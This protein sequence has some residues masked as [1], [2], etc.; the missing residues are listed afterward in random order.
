MIVP[1]SDPGDLWLRR[2]ENPS[3]DALSLGQLR[4]EGDRREAKKLL[5][6]ARRG[7]RAI[8]DE[9]AEVNRYGDT[10]N[11]DELSDLLPDQE[12]IA[13]DRTLTTH[14]I[15]PRRK[16]SDTFTIITEE[17]EGKGGGEG[18]NPRD[19][20]GDEER[21]D[22][23]E[24]GEEHGEDGDTP[25]RYRK[26]RAVLRRVRYIPLSHDEAIIAFDPTPDSV[27]PEVRLSLV[28]AGTERD[29][30]GNQRVAITAATRVGDT[31][32]PLELNDGQILFT[33]DST[34][35]VTVRLVADGNL[36]QRAFRLI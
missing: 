36:D 17:S 5:R 21:G 26:G 13:G 22:D 31:E 14:V 30:R 27:T 15:E 1:D 10:T 12:G 4:N 8:I 2:M 34:E 16:P 32:E 23:G 18:E 11:I 7:L 3:H 33:P 28:P 29:L 6:Q 24:G 19:R 35:R 20:T 25:I 9:K